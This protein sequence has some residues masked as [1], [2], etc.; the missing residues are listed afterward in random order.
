MEDELINLFNLSLKKLGWFYECIT[1]F[2]AQLFFKIII[3]SKN[4]LYLSM[5]NHYEFFFLLLVHSKP[6]HFMKHVSF[7]F[8]VNLVGLNSLMLTLSYIF[9]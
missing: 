3:C 5:H 8:L 4:A 9:G 6:C 2:K 1:T 7:G